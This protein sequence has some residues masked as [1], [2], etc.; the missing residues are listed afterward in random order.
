MWRSEAAEL[1]PG[2]QIRY[3]GLIYSRDFLGGSVFLC[4]SKNVPAL[5]KMLLSSHDKPREARVNTCSEDLVPVLELCMPT[6][7]SRQLNPECMGTDCCSGPKWLQLFFPHQGLTLPH[8]ILGNSEGQR[9][10]WGQVLHLRCA[11]LIYRE[12]CC[13]IPTLAEGITSHAA[14]F[15]CRDLFFS[16]CW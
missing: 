15:G 9:L 1:C 3:A 14:G 11:E 12:T 5:P 2:T 16:W 4:E 7:I 8:V 10:F 6:A 13:E